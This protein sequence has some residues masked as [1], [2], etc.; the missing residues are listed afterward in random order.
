MFGGRRGLSRGRS[1]FVDRIS[2]TGRVWRVDVVV[3][4]LSGDDYPLSAVAFSKRARAYPFWSDRAAADE[5]AARGA[6]PEKVDYA[7]QG[8]FVSTVLP[9]LYA[10][11]DLVGPEWSRWLTGSEVEP[12]ELLADIRV[13]PTRSKFRV[14]EAAARRH[15]VRHDLEPLPFRTIGRL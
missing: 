8:H 11:G 15:L 3:D 5:A 10:H 1:Q 7:A 9:T 14:E 4:D 2:A 13:A 6:I 12:L